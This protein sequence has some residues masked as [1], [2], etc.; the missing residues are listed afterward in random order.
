MY[1]PKFTITNKILRE[2]GR[3]E[4]SK[5]IIDHAPLLPYYEREFRK[6]A[7]VP[8]F[9]AQARHHLEHYLRGRQS[10]LGAN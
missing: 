8:R 2:I 9:G 10:R 5:E 4:A 3:V 6:D 1:T 7:L